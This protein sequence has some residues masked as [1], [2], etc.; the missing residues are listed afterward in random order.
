MHA[1]GFL[2]VE[3]PILSRRSGGATAT[4]FRTKSTAA[5]DD[6]DGDSHF[7]RISPELALKQCVVGGMTKVYELGRVFRDESSDESHSPEFT[8]LEW[9]TQCPDCV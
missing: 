7:L 3:T 1:R 5:D 8:M 6:D 9:C 2:E 4:P